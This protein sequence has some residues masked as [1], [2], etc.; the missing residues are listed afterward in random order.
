MLTSTSFI[1]W[2]KLLVSLS[3]SLPLLFSITRVSSTEVVSNLGFSMLAEDDCEL[4]DNYCV[5]SSGFSSH[6]KYKPNES[7]N[8]TVIYGRAAWLWNAGWKYE[9]EP[10]YKDYFIINGTKFRMFCD[11]LTY[12]EG[13]KVHPNTKIYW[14]SD[15][16]N[17]YFG[18]RF[19]LYDSVDGYLLQNASF[20]SCECSGEDATGFNTGYGEHCGSHGDIGIEEDTSWCNTSPDSCPNAFRS[21]VANG[22]TI[23]WFFCV[24]SDSP[25]RQP[26]EAP[27]IKY[28]NY[29]RY[30]IAVLILLCCCIGFCTVKYR[31][32]YHRETTDVLSHP[33]RKEASRFLDEEEMTKFRKSLS[34]AHS[35]QEFATED[36]VDLEANVSDECHSSNDGGS[37]NDQS[38]HQTVNP[39]ESVADWEHY[40]ELL[41]PHEYE[42]KLTIE[43]KDIAHGSFGSISLAHASEQT[44]KLAVKN[45]IKKWD[46]MEDSEKYDFLHEIH[47]SI[48]LNHKNIVRLFGVKYEPVEVVYEYC[49]HGSFIDMRTRGETA[50]LNFFFRLRLLL[51]ACRGLIYLVQKHI[52]HLDIAARNILIDEFYRGKISDFGRSQ[53]FEESCKVKDPKLPLKWSA[54]ETLLRLEC[55]EKSDVWA[56]GITM[57]EIITDQWPYEELSPVDACIKVLKEDYRLPLSELHHRLQKLL[58]SCWEFDSEKRPTMKDIGV[59]LK[60]IIS[61]YQQGRWSSRSVNKY[62]QDTMLITS[63]KDEKIDGDGFEDTTCN[64]DTN[65]RL[66]FRMKSA[67][68]TPIRSPHNTFPQVSSPNL[69]PNFFTPEPGVEGTNEYFVMDEPVYHHL[70]DKTG[71]KFGTQRFNI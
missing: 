7:C 43:K 50:G 23:R 15:S 31:K 62:K 33:R 44:M 10:S 12:N 45:Y 32:K 21:C 30:A 18:W 20:S 40:I 61:E 4:Y 58:S 26:T 37:D 51:D 1:I 28:T 49:L 38:S 64:S 46:D 16:T 3:F 11:D 9:V 41:R 2:R 24:D 39:E 53:K 48:G 13:N 5:Q 70:D 59:K 54:P 17:E 55:S 42:E 29:S 69:K 68:I 52:L 34:M 19:C 8:I 65:D 63:E 36:G 14:R 67:P 47:L 27:A 35:L 60:S 6:S 57:W 71:R 25:T 66:N 56:L 22:D